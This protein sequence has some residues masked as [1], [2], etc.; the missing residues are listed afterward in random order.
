MNASAASWHVGRAAAPPPP[1]LSLRP[2]PADAVARI[3]T[4]SAFFLDGYRRSGPIFRF[5]RGDRTFTVL[6]GREANLFMTQEGGAVLR[7]DLY[8]EEQNRELQI[9]KNIVSLN[10]EEH[11]RLRNLQRHGYSRAALEARYPELVEAVRR[12]VLAW[13]TETPILVRDAFPRLIAELLGI[14]V[15]S[16]PVG[17]FF[18][19][20]VLFVRTVVIETVARTRPRTILGTPRYEE[21]KAR[22]LALAD[23]VI[24]AHREQ[25]HGPGRPDLV[26]D[27]LAAVDRDPT[28]MDEQELRISVLGGYIGG[29]DT[30]A[31]TCSFLLYSL[32]AHPALLE[33]ATAE[34]DAVFSHGPLTPKALRGLKCL[35]HASLET[36]RLYPLSAAIQA[37]VAQPFEF[38]G[39]GVEEGEDLIVA[40]TVP[41]FLEE[42]YPRPFDF[43]IERYAEPRNEHRQPGGFAPFGIGPH[44]C[45]GAGM[46][47]VLI[48]LTMATLL[49]TVRLA[50]DPPDYRLEI[51][52]IPVPVP[53]NFYL[54]VRERRTEPPPSDPS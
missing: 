23:K 31:Y 13:P 2:L 26:D 19:D 3:G 6:A 27:L 42:I 14:G 30:V 20:L 35:H 29:L 38:A 52:M 18:D 21:A 7:A 17:D 28:L 25:P 44:I 40:T 10:G 5:R 48:L 34:V 46:A 15:L 49:H 8:R 12:L 22:S 9:E 37:T 43:E 33:K 50:M 41:H 24:A 36:L 53:E 45:L 54:T 11:L 16:Y 32:L 1:W 39:H 4:I 47:E 51:G